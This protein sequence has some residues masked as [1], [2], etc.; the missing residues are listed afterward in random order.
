MILL[1]MKFSSQFLD[2]LTSYSRAMEASEES[3]LHQKARQK[4]QKCLSLR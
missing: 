3:D 2:D 4:S 1:A